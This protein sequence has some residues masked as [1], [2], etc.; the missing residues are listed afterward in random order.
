MS[1]SPPVNVTIKCHFVMLHCGVKQL[2]MCFW[3]HVMI[4][5]N[6]CTNLRLSKLNHTFK[7]KLKHELIVVSY[8]FRLF[9]SEII[10]IQTP[11][12]PNNKYIQ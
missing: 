1:V 10:V 4:G 3:L 2:P 9:P 12:K 6:T 11:P 5:P 7:F 8:L